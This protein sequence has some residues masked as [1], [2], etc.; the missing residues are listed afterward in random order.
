LYKETSKKRLGPEDFQCE[1]IS[2]SS[3]DSS[4]TNETTSEDK[5]IESTPN[6]IKKQTYSRLKSS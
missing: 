6:K 5:E 4:D 3:T 1:Q 2:N